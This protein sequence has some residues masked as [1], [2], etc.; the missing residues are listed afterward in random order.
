VK[1]YRRPDGR[2]GIR[3]RVMVA[4]SVECAKFVAERIVSQTPGTELV[5]FTGCYH[6]PYA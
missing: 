2:I 4:Y 5:G 3:N 1:G 6:D